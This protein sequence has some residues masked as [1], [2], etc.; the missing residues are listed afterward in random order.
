MMAIQ[1]G[2]PFPSVNAK[3]LLCKWHIIRV[4]RRKIQ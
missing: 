1:D 3:H 2:M 4:W